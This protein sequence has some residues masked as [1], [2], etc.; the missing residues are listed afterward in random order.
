MDVTRSR[1]ETREVRAFAI[2]V[3]VQA[4]NSNQCAGI[5]SVDGG[6]FDNWYAEFRVLTAGVVA[7]VADEGKLRIHAKGDARLWRGRY[8]GDFAIAIVN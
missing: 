8:G 6:E 1:H 3:E 2:V 4:I 7:R 5:G